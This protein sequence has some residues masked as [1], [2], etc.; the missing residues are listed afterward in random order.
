MG[1][2][3]T[4]D[5]PRAEALKAIEAQLIHATN[6]QLSDVLFALFSDNP[7]TVPHNFTIDEEGL[8]TADYLLGKEY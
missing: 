1:I 2:Y 4:L 8:G 7:N 5:I 6:E 3:S